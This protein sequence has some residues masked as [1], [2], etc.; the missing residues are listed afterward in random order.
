MD[1]D[2]SSGVTERQREGAEQGDRRGA[3]RVIICRMQLR[4]EDSGSHG[5]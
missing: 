5:F 1:T 4:F 3:G 2:S